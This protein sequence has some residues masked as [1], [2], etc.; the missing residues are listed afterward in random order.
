MCYDIKI[1]RE[2]VVLWATKDTNSLVYQHYTEIKCC[3]LLALWFFSFQVWSPGEH[4]SAVGYAVLPQ[5]FFG[6][7]ENKNLS[8]HL[9]LYNYT[10][11][12]NVFF[13]VP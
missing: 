5:P 13:S 1:E 9:L 8:V 12:H 10:L 11:Y 4:R 3:F 7:S 2:G 6:F